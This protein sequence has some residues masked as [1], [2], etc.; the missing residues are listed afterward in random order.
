MKTIST[1]LVIAAAMFLTYVPISSAEITAEPCE[2]GVQIKVDG[3]L[4]ARYVKISGTRPILWPV[5]GP[6]GKRVTRGYP[7]ED[8]GEHERANYD[9]HRSLWFGHGDVGDVSFWA[10]EGVI[11]HR[12]FVKME[13]GSEAVVVARNDWMTPDF[14]P[15]DPKKVIEDERT[16]TFGADDDSRWIDV[17][18]VLTASEEEVLIGG[19]KDAGFGV[20]VA[21]TMKPDAGLG[22]RMVN[23]RGQADRDAWGKQAEWLDCYGPV[24]GETVGIAILNHPSSFRFP[25]YWHVRT[26]GLA[27]A[28]PFGLWDFTKGE[29]DGDHILEKGES[30]RLRHRVFLHKGDTESGKVAEAFEKYAEQE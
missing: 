12:E 9:H 10:D 16:L 14:F 17:D 15:G 23:S 8:L 18:I 7:M 29:K 25:T 19:V 26:Y 24:D 30:L 4:F 21:G 22:G 20:Q 5:V 1:I 28:N 27:L 6:T 11:Q 3:E 2:E 13:S